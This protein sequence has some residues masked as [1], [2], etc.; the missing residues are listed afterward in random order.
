[1][2]C[3]VCVLVFVYLC[4]LFVCGGIKS[5]AESQNCSWNIL[6]FSKN[7]E[8]SL[9]PWHHLSHNNAA[10]CVPLSSVVLCCCVFPAHITSNRRNYKQLCGK[11]T[12]VILQ[13]RLRVTE[14]HEYQH[15]CDEFV[16]RKSEPKSVTNEE[17]YSTNS[18][19]WTARWTASWANQL[20][21]AAVSSSQWLPWWRAAPFVLSIKSTD[22]QFLHT[23]ALKKHSKYKTHATKQL[24]FP[25]VWCDHRTCEWPR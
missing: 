19:F 4:C 7:A 8:M 13:G 11:T 23:A 3:H 10:V 15:T 21:A 24:L 5:P 22:G 20:I 9:E 12:N 17:E 18:W 1:M 14:L 25:S 16:A 2:L 6:R